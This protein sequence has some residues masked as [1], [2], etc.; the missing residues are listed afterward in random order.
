MRLYWCDQCNVPRF[1]DS[2]CSKCGTIPRRVPI[3]PPGD[4]FPAMEGH[5]QRVVEAIDHQFGEGVGSLVIPDDR[6]IVFNKVS[7]IDAMFEVVVDG[8]IIG[9]LRFDLPALKYTFVLSLEGGRRIAQHTKQKWVTCHDEVLP[10]LRKG[11]SLLVPGV[12]GC[13]AEI[14]VGDEVIL[15]DTEGNAIGVGM[16]RMS[17]RDIAQAA[18]GLAVKIREFAD[19]MP[20]QINPRSSSWADAVQAN[21]ADLDRIESEAIRF[22][23]KTVERHRLPV[24]VGFSGGK[25]SLATYLLVEKALG[26]SPPMFFMDT[27]LELPET[28]QY[29]LETAE[30]H[31]AEIIGEQAGDRFWESLPAFG[32]PA[33]DFRW[34]CKVLK[35]GP[36]ATA[37]AQRMSGATLAFMGQR[38]LESFR[39]SVEPRVTSNPWVPGQTSANPIQRWNALEVWL[40]IFRENE[41]FNPLYARGYHRMGCYLCP[42]SP[43]AEIEGLR[44]THPDLYERWQSYLRDWASQH[45]LPHEWVTLGFWRW[46]HLPRGQQELAKKLGIDLAPERVSPA[47]EMELRVVKGISPCVASGFSMEGQFTSGIDIN[48]VSQ[49]LPIF[50]KT[51]VSEEMGAVWVTR[52][53]SSIMLFSSGSVVIR[54]PDE[55]TVERLVGPLERAIRRAMFCQACGSCIPQC[56]Y[57]ALKIAADGKIAVD[58]DKCIRC[59]RCDEWPCPTY[60]S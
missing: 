16:A 12:A 14:R 34:C 11:A 52:G 40:Y 54:A 10:Y 58:P 31:G 24:V 1:E 2:P 51:R 47:Q 27:G 18:R 37:I 7:S 6:T 29:V 42:A 56:E 59:L 21:A 3:S 19:H 50:G 17:G 36:A 48:R 8:H 57:N 60:L 55:S 49:L 53:P 33:R 26:H 38:R 9:R 39:R 35:L 23:R 32:P 41:P 44:T 45:G 15:L 30:R 4:P 28:V 20:P 5:L 43:L 25:D 13:D 46:K 22:I